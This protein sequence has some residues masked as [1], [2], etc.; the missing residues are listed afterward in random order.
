MTESTGSR[1]V[2]LLGFAA[3]LLGGLGAVSAPAGQRPAGPEKFDH[4]TL[5]K[6]GDELAK[7][8]DAKTDGP[9]VR[10]DAERLLAA[11]GPETTARKIAIDRKLLPPEP[12]PKQLYA[13]ATSAWVEFRAGRRKIPVEKPLTD[14]MIAEFT[15]DGVQVSFTTPKDGADV[16]IEGVKCGTTNDC[17]RTMTKGQSYSVDFMRDGSKDHQ[18]FTPMKNPDV[19]TGKI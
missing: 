5:L 6:F 15:N 12:S 11:Y 16:Y 7:K 3:A 19:C 14:R 10:R 17:F 9:W 1:R 13:L 18:D 4:A 2:A 8:V